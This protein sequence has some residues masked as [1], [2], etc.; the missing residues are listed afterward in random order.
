MAI[1]GY[2]SKNEFI[3]AHSGTPYWVSMIGFVPGT[4]WCFQMV[5]RDV[6]FR[7]RSTCVRV[8]RVQAHADPKDGG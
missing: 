3:A 2:S 7:L 5:S 4:A 6:R 1:N 8:T